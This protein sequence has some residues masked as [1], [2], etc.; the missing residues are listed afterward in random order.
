MKQIKETRSFK[1]VIPN[2]DVVKLLQEVGYEIPDDVR[3]YVFDDT[4][5][6]NG[7]VVEKNEL[8]VTWQREQK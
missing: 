5:L 8:I 3:L 1:L 2:E 6:I 7:R 4:S